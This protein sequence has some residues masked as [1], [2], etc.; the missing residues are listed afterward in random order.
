MTDR[1]VRQLA[2]ALAQT[3]GSWGG[4]GLAVLRVEEDEKPMAEA[5]A[6]HNGAEIVVSTGLIQQVVNWITWQNLVPPDQVQGHA[7]N[8]LYLLYLHEI[9]HVTDGHILFPRAEASQRGRRMA[10]HP[11]ALVAARSAFEFEADRWALQQFV[12][13]IAGGENMDA[14]SFLL[15]VFQTSFAANVM[16]EV[17][18]RHVHA[19]NGEARMWSALGRFDESQIHP[20]LLERRHLMLDC[21]VRMV[22]GDVPRRAVE[23]VWGSGTVLASPRR[24]EPQPSLLGIPFA[25]LAHEYRSPHALADELELR[26]ALIRETGLIPDAEETQGAA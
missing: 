17:V 25:E 12:W 26:L 2:D 11:R 9:R 23:K 3:H 4:D 1:L 5:L 8:A 24:A 20:P 13:E 10:A 22:D 19:R 7:L 18:D 15:A 16:T 21:L 14:A 6:V